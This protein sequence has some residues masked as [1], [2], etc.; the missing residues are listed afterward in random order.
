M[1]QLLTTR[2]GDVVDLT[3]LTYERP[4]SASV[5]SPEIAIT[6]TFVAVRDENRVTHV[7]T[8]DSWRAFVLDIRAG[9]WNI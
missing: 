1:R 5:G 7:Y 2:E 3:K 9:R 8:I 6:D 4:F